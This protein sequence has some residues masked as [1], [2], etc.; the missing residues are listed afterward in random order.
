MSNRINNK[1]IVTLS[2]QEE[3]NRQDNI[4]LRQEF[5]KHGFNVTNFSTITEEDIPIVLDDP[6]TMSA[7]DIIEEKVQKYRAKL[8]KENQSL[9]QMSWE[10]RLQH[11]A[12]RFKFE[13]SIS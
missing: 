1:E 8:I 7:E 9:S 11:E 2:P 12:V 6:L 5:A 13:K 3:Y 10:D 4:R